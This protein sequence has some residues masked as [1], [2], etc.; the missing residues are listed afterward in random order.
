[1]AA[2][3]RRPQCVRA[4]G[5]RVAIRR[6]RAA[7]DCRGR[8][9]NPAGRTV[10]TLRVG[11]MSGRTPRAALG[12]LGLLCVALIAAWWHHHYERVERTVALP[13]AG[14]PAYNPLY[15]LRRALQAEGI[16]VRSRQRLDL[17]A[18]AP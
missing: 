15:A 11:A 1:L 12:V 10:A 13:P 16:A 9:R 2:G 18:H 8:V 4:H 17:A 3:R 14:E 5:P 6:L 7:A